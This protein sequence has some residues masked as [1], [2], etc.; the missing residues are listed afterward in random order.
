VSLFGRL[1]SFFNWSATAPALARDPV[2]VST[3]RP[4]PSTD[5][6]VP[7]RP[8]GP[9]ARF[10]FLPYP[11]S[12]YSD[13]PEIKA[14]MRLML[15]DP[16]VKSAW[17][18]GV[19]TV[20]A[21]DF[22]V[23]ASD[24]N[25]PLA[26]QQ[27][28]FVRRV[29]DNADGGM[30]SVVTSILNPM[31][32]DGYSLSEKV[33][34]VEAT[35][36][37][38]GRI[39][40]RKLKA[41]RPDR[42]R[43]HGDQFNNVT[44]VQSCLAQKTWP[45]S[46]F[47]YA[48]YMPV[49]DEA[50]GVAPFR[51]AYAAYWM[52]D[53]VR[54][55]RVIHHEKKI[56]GM[57]VGTYT[58]PADKAGL[59]DA[60]SR[61]KTATWMAVPEGV[62]VAAQQI[63]TAS[64]TEYAQFV[65]DCRTDIV[66]GITFASLQI[67][68]G[69]TPDARGDSKVQKSISDLAPW[70]LT[71][72]VTEALNKQVVPDLVDYNFPRAPVGYPKVSFGAV[73]N[74][75]Q[76][77]LCDLLGRAQQLGL[78]P[79]K[80]YYARILT[81]QEADPLDPA[82]ALTPAGQGMGGLPGMPPGADPTQA[83]QQLPPG[84][85]PFGQPPPPEPGGGDP[86]AQAGQPE[87][88]FAERRG[89]QWV[90]DFSWQQGK[91]GG[92]YWLPA[93]K[94][95]EA[96]FRLYGAKAEAAARAAEDAPD[97]KAEGATS[98]GRPDQQPTPPAPAPQQALADAVADRIRAGQGLTAKQLFEA[99]NRLYGGTRAGGTYGPSQAYDAL[100]AGLNAALAGHTDP[101]L[102]TA[103]AVEQARKIAAT[104][105]ALPTQTNRS[106]NKD[107][108]QQFSTPPH[109][110][111]AAAWL[112]NLTPTDTVLEPSA[113]TGSLAVHA[114]N[115]GAT[116]KG[117]ELDPARAALLKRLIGDGNVTEENAEQIGAILRG[118]VNP[119]VV[120]MNPPFS[121]T[122]GRLGDSK[123]LLTATRHIDEALALLPAG[124]RLVA[125]VGMGMLPPGSEITHR[126]RKQD[127]SRYAGWFRR[128]MSEYSLRANVG[129]PG[130]EYA[131]MGTQ[132]GTRVLVIDKVKGGGPPVTGDAADVPGLME[133]L[134]DVRNSRPGVESRPG[135]PAG[136]GGTPAAGGAAAGP[137][138]DGGGRRRG[139]GAAVRAGAAAGGGGAGGAGLAG[140]GLGGGA[141]GG[142][143]GG[144]GGPAGGAA[145]GPGG[146]RAGRQ[147]GGQP[148]AQVPGLRPAVETAYEYKPDAD[149]AVAAGGQERLTDS[150]Y[151]PYSPAVRVPG[152]RPHESPLVESAAM[153]AVRP[154]PPTYKP[155]LS[156][157]V[158]EKGLLSDAALETLVYAGQA[159][160]QML[161]AIP[162]AVPEKGMPARRR[163]YFIGDGT[164]VGKSRQIAAIIADNANQGRKKAVW[165]TKKADAGLT[166]GANAAFAEIGETT[167]VVPFR[168]F[169]DAV[170]EARPADGVLLV[171][172]DTLKS[173]P[174]DKSQPTNLDQLVQWLGPDYDGVV[175][176]DE[177]HL[178]GAATS[179]KGLMGDKSAS[180]RAL[181]GLELQKRLPN[182]RVVYASA[183]GA[184]KL[185]NLA[186]AD[187]LGLW[188]PGTAFPTRDSFFSGL[189]SGG[190]AAMEAV[191]QSLKANGLYA[192]RTLSLDDGTPQG[193]VR[194]DRVTHTMTPDQRAMYD[195]A[196]EGWQVV[197]QNMEKAL[198]VTGARKNGR[199]VAMARG[200]FWGSQQ[201]F[202]DQ[203]M[204]SIQTPSVLAA[205]EEDIKAGRAPVVQL[206]KTNDAQTQRAIK[207]L[208]DD[209]GY[210]DVDI[211]P[212][213]VLID[214]INKSFPTQ[215]YEEY[216]DPD[217]KAKKV[218]P[219]L[220]SN[221]VAVEDPDMVRQRDDLIERIG[222]G[223][224]VPSG[225]LDQ[226]VEHF[227]P[228][229]VAEATGRPSRLVPGRLPDGRTGPVLEKRG[230]TAR[231]NAADAAAFQAGTKKALV[232]SNAGGTGLDYHADKRAGNQGQRVHYMLQPGWQADVAVQG[233]GRTH[234]TNQASAPQYRLVQIDGLD[235]Q[236]R[237]VS[238]IARRLDQLG[239]LTK[240]QR[241]TGSS[242]LFKAADNL[243]SPQ[244]A[245]AMEDFFNDLEA[246]R[247]PDLPYKQTATRLG[248]PPPEKIGESKPRPD[249]VTQFLNRLLSLPVA[250]Q[251][252]VFGEFERRLADR[253]AAAVA[254]G[255]VDV[256][257]ANY[258]AE[259]VAPVRER[260]VY[261]NPTT[262]AQVKL[263]TVAV[264][265]RVPKRPFGAPPAR[266]SGNEGYVTNDRSGGVWEVYPATDGTDT[267]TGRVYPRKFLVGPA[268]TNKV[269]PAWEVTANHTAV[270]ADQAK[271]LW[272]QQ[273]AAI[274]DVSES[275]EHF[276]SGALLDV[277]D[278]LPEKDKP[279]VWRVKPD[280]KPAIVGRQVPAADL[281]KV[282]KDFGVAADA[283]APARYDPADVHRRL[284]AGAS[285]QLAGGW[286]LA[287]ARVQG[288]QRIE[289]R[290]AGLTDLPALDAAG[291]VKERVGYATRYFVP[292]GPAGAEVLRRLAAYKPI[293]AVTD[294]F[295]E[296]PSGRATPG[297]QSPV[298]SAAVLA[299]IRGDHARSRRVR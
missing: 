253:V 115:A 156:P 66:T 192:A 148:A 144:A 102:D 251:T 188:G 203:L 187:R 33:W 262:G 273:F 131:K 275:E 255:K 132:F 257:M 171:G 72:Q 182:A 45:I 183:T 54:K 46:D 210:E 29:F 155:H 232:F 237:F 248:F 71:Y 254:T 200:Q 6:R 289:I 75:E 100:E 81:I 113:G 107:A 295:A 130:S 18:S 235:A 39:T 111:Y 212:R 293:T 59:E 16:Y 281:P 135:A 44:G 146:R 179:E 189:E 121:A 211:S 52:H 268:G 88:L 269:V 225:A 112:A 163:G 170:P 83:G 142:A 60:L 10:F 62:R 157:D 214:Y 161:P 69:Q 140:A 230:D 159:H 290:G 35:G 284:T 28:D 152:A 145:A 220:D 93:G 219:V 213:Q 85:D 138:G 277:W 97:P 227:G 296:P 249:R 162:N 65:A 150:A 104:A 110:A 37:D 13:P 114:K 47:V 38:R 223:L 119:T 168:K 234:R 23:H 299:V 92:R 241:E 125:I 105:A 185:S 221:G 206:V 122:A 231:A 76:L 266:G 274:P 252:V 260:V 80:K 264:T 103:A 61:A 129:V 259:R 89:G 133:M 127:G 128:V 95:D 34:Q 270:P 240:G 172:Y 63:S 180:D 21:Q 27:A 166:R 77:Q 17:L 90:E 147:R 57:L 194:Y 3:R 42:V 201:R 247:I 256:G 198:D 2:P 116:V 141:A 186:Y 22:Q 233:L 7:D 160:S 208:D 139:A 218:R 280:G 158:I 288:E 245:E 250:D 137:P 271:A 143:T 197:M 117:N 169:L 184:T 101:T 226:I 297:G 298:P 123:D 267:R 294:Q 26:K 261:T 118:K 228:S 246:G 32:S 68:E 96:R 285:A 207:E 282:L 216:Y 153:A 49:Y 272:D 217:T 51:A 278:R 86:M 291:A 19:L 164:G 190:V 199:A 31:G 4:L 177:A 25:D 84:G 40:L 193:T 136:D 1:K 263:N 11:D 292:T 151:S 9:S 167:A 174:K 43:L 165:V 215:R 94:P 149:E 78:K 229:Q 70:Y 154:P 91:R 12:P 244:A 74:Q 204:T 202:F 191:A 209:Q 134:A 48:R 106:G 36:P 82:D 58:D 98:S 5:E 195:A 73:S 222:F 279:K 287:P 67:L 64:D 56:G 265:R 181:A 41:K 15:R 124:G 126:G 50:D 196:A 178:M 24:D 30:V 79:S 20:A 276:I 55:L 109:L 173:G 175:A 176:F 239:A 205:M 283:A 242:G 53:T 238:T 243:E 8:G 236:K 87:G 286:S 224:R 99:A 14:A 108:L 258:P 120:V